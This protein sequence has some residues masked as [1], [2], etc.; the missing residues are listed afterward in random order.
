MTSQTPISLY[1][2][3]KLGT[4]IAFVE[5]TLLIEFFL[6]NRSILET[7]T[8]TSLFFWSWSILLLPAPFIGGL[9]L[10][11]SFKFFVY[12]FPLFFLYGLIALVIPTQLMARTISI[13]TI[14]VV[15]IL[16]FLAKRSRKVFD[17]EP[18][19]NPLIFFES[20]VVFGLSF[21]CSHIVISLDL[22]DTIVESLSVYANYLMLGLVFYSAFSAITIS[23]HFFKKC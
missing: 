15:L 16:S 19:I 23:L 21:L 20:I 2:K 6:E 13:L 22:I 18:T 14:I 8:G 1:L 4:I 17:L 3:H 5:L 10:K 9:S 7:A 11:G 12:F